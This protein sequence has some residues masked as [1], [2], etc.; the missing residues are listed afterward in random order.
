MEWWYFSGHVSTPD[1]GQYSFHF[2]GFNFTGVEGLVPSGVTA[3]VMHLTL[4]SPDQGSLLKEARGGIGRGDIPDR[5]FSVAIGDWSMSGIGEEFRL[6][7]GGRDEGFDLQLEPVKDVVFHDGDGLLDMGPGGESYY[8]SYPRLVV[9]GEVTAGGETRNVSGQAW[10]DHQW[11]E[12]VSAKVGWDW[13]SFQLDGGEEAM[14]FSL[15]DYETREPV[16]RGGTFVGSDG[17]VRYLEDE[18]IEI[19]AIDVWLSPRTGIAYPSGW[20][21]SIPPLS[22][23]LDVRPTHPDAE[24]DVEVFN[25]LAY[26]EGQVSVAGVRHSEPVSGKG[27]VELVG[28]DRGVVP[29]RPPPPPGG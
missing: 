20:R 10:M 27:F 5:G 29:L 24:F 18:D 2:A 12:I 1:D 8:Y 14:V 7:V 11:G 4:A 13:F 22:L 23:D 16:R 28:Y 21:V 19:S 6:M 15:W 17:G 3:R 9:R 25:P 26:W